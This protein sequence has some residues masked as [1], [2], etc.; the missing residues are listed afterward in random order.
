MTRFKHYGKVLTALFI[1]LVLIF[2]VVSRY[3]SAQYLTEFAYSFQ[4]AFLFMT[5][6]V[7]LKEVW[8][9]DKRVPFSQ[10]DLVMIAIACLCLSD[11]LETSAR[12][13]SRLQGTILDDASIAFYRLIAVFFVAVLISLR[14]YPNPRI[15][16]MWDWTTLFLISLGGGVCIFCYVLL[17]RLGS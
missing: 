8:L 9:R 3:I 2:F 10:I 14:G 7:F 6:Y 4:I 12:L 17:Q 5:T 13:W 11:G 16:K 15:S 1:S